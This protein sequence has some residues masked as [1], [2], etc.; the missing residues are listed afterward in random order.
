MSLAYQT[1]GIWK[2]IEELHKPST[3]MAQA[4]DIYANLIEDPGCTDP[5]IAELAAWDRFFL[6]LAICNRND[7]K[8]PWIYDRCREVEHDPDGY[9]DLWFREAGKSSLGTFLGILQ[10]IIRDPEIT[11]GI[12]SH[13]RPIA[14]SFLRQIKMELE[15]N[16]KFNAYWPHIFWK[17]PKKEAS[18]WNEDE[19]ITVKRRSNPKEA[20][21]E[22]SGLVDSQP[23]G[24][25][26]RLM[27][28][29]DV[30]TERSVGTPEMI[31]KTTLAWELSRNL[32][33]YDDCSVNKD[34]RTWYLGTRYSYS[35][36][37][38]IM[39]ARNAAI[40]RIYPATDTGTPDGRSIY[41]SEREWERKKRELSDF[42]LACLGKG[43]RILMADWTTRPIEQI[44]PD[45]MV[46]GVKLNKNEGKAVK[47]RL[48]PTRVLAI[49]TKRSKVQRIIL[50]S[51][52]V[53]TC[54]PDHKWWTG[55]I[56]NDTHR[57]YAKAGF[58]YRDV[59]GL[60]R[61]LNFDLDLYTEEERLAASYLAGLFDGE[62]ASN[63]SC[64][65]ITQSEKHNPEVCNKLRKTLSYLGYP[66]TEYRRKGKEYQIYFI[67]TGGRQGVFRFLNQ[68]KP[69]K[70]KGLIKS[71][72]IT[73][74]R[75]NFFKD[76]L[77]RI[78]E[79]PEEQDVHNI[80]TE[81]GNY[82][83]EGYV[84][85]NCQYL[86]N[87]VAGSQQEFKPEWVR[88]WEIRPE[89]LNL[90]ILCDPANS[91]KPGSCNTAFAVI[92]VDHASNKYLLD[93]AC[94]KMNLEERWKML[95]YL[96]YKWIGQPGIQSVQVGY[97]KYGMQ[98]D[99][100]HFEIMMRIEQKS[101]PIY[102]V[103]WARDQGGHASSQ[104]KDDRIRRLIPDHKNWRFFYPYEGDETK[105]MVQT[106]EKGK[107]YLC[108]RPIMRKNQDG[109]VYNLV[110]WYKRNEYLFFP[111]TTA[112]DFGDAMSR[113]Y[114]LDVQP[115]QF[116]KDEDLNPKY[117]GDA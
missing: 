69:S 77:S 47:S 11:V 1:T 12:F 32:S 116:L 107:G 74:T 79:I 66:Y 41:F 73:S 22:A 39:L 95:S 76:N 6:G 18:L 80:Q 64:I 115:P 2:I 42:T 61:V 83:A 58:G 67:I 109:R 26:F 102:P 114:D 38:G 17:N 51:G 40:P 72:T 49:N 19:G 16:P 25:H 108:A 52:K 21:V 94:H 27:V 71:L 59:K 13:T 35:D 65:C 97:E 103:S 55:R 70:V 89:I 36:T 106:S 9:L 10:E 82:I 86:L 68:S 56:G 98:C 54:T 81:L 99:Q 28:Y 3:S 88:L 96:Y 91:K 101:F 8:H 111:A 37:Y 75:L 112:K 100:E 50:Q 15:Q 23:T 4:L 78:V 30:V 105:L 110:E 7:L 5:M 53:I 24:K 14:K 63:S 84:S 87:P 20:T 46:L 85:K 45:D 104:K 43:T 33:A 92:G 44:R 34:R 48:E 31:L 60:R 117:E 62:G 57:I 113:I 29:D 90:G 93:G